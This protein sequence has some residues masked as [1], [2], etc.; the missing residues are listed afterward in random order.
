MDNHGS[1]LKVYSLQEQ[2]QLLE[3]YCRFGVWRSI[4]L[5]HRK[6][7]EIEQLMLERVVTLGYEQYG[8]EMFRQTRP[9]LDRES[10][11]EAADMVARETVYELIERGIIP[12]GG[13]E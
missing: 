5:L 13:R 3:K 12:E 9:E 7:V 8:D 1:R 11:E 4:S 6:H 2:R 10:R